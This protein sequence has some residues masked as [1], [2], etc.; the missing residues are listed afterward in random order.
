MNFITETDSCEFRRKRLIM[1][2]DSSLILN[3]LPLQI[4][5]RQEKRAQRLTFW[6]RRPPGGV[7][8]FH[9]MGW[10][11]KSSC[12]PSKVCLPWVSKRG[13]WDVPGILPGCFF[14]TLGGVQKVCAKKGRAHFSFPN[15]LRLRT[16]CPILQ[17]HLSHDSCVASHRMKHNRASRYYRYK[18]RVT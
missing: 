8:V 10:W 2:A 14:R 4:Q 11:P 18:Y 17:Q 12:P 9:A 7:G 6:V 16:N 15:R 13:I 1:D 3:Q 5:I